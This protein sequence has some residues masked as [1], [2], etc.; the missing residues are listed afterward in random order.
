M[1]PYLVVVVDEVIEAV[2]LLQE[3]VGSGLGG[4]FLQG[5]VHALMSAVLLGVAGLDA[6]DVDA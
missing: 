2:L 3:V 5:Q 4:F 1:W 6:F